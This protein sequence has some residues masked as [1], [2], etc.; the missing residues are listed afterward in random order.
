MG[1]CVSKPDRRPHSSLH[2]PPSTSPQPSYHTPP[3]KI[4]TPASYPLTASVPATLN[5]STPTLYEPSFPLSSSPLCRRCAYRPK[6]RDT[7]SVNNTNGNAG[8]PYYICIR[9]KN[10]QTIISVGQNGKGWI[11]WDDRRGINSRNPRCNCGLLARQDR[12]GLNT[13]APGAGFWTCSTGACGYVSWRKDGLGEAEA[14]GMEDGGFVPW[15][16]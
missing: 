12:A 7:V 8:R 2:G 9:C 5:F 16:I 13:Y 14:G 1:C 3:P 6:Y 15:L 11:T 4:Y 10:D